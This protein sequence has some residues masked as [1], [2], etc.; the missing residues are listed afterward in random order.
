[1]L[2]TTSPLSTPA[3]PSSLGKN[4]NFQVFWLGQTLSLFGDAF[5]ALAFPLLVLQS[6]GSLASMGAV[7][8]T[9]G[10]GMCLSAVVSG[11]LVDRLDRRRI[12]LFCDWSRLLLFATIPLVW[13]LAGPQLWLL[14]AVA[15]LGGLLGN[16]FGVAAITALTDLVEREQLIDANSRLMTSFAVVG[17][18]GPVAAGMLSHRTG[19]A[20]VVLVDALSFAVSA[21]CLHSVRMRPADPAEPRADGPLFRG[22]LD[23]VRFL[24][25]HPV[26]RWVA[27]LLGAATLLTA[28]RNDLLVFHIKSLG[29]SD[30]TVG[31]VF[32]V[33]SLGA[34][35][36]GALAPRL[37]RRWGFGACWL[38]AG[39]LQGAALV[40]GGQS[41]T[42]HAFALMAMALA[43]T[44]TIRG[45]NSMSYR[46]ETTPRHLLGRVTSAFWMLLNVPS[47]L[48]AA[49]AAGVAEKLGVPTVVTGVGALLLVVVAV[50]LLG[51][52]RHT[53]AGRA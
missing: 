46:Q 45:I 52:L 26:L 5:S 19:P 49:A 2:A 39:A 9:G 4:R 13:W 41:P 32:G 7:T 17:A 24:F 25:G 44:D 33:A 36:G 6:T 30:D 51:P 18:L 14:Y 53:S 15:F 35:V 48:G 11:P 29:G 8:A 28:A 38:G 31:R 12:M 47:A 27:A 10:A 3:Q 21:L 22:L 1:M 42:L 23:G 43:M 37:R 50:G 20:F 16:L 34:V 40:V